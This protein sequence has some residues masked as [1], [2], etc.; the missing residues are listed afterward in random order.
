MLAEKSNDKE[1]KNIICF[2]IGA[3]VRES[4]FCLQVLNLPPELG[5]LGHLVIHKKYMNMLS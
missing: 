5:A 3:F 1:K 4:K 2:V